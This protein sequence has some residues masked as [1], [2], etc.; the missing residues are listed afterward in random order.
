[1]LVHGKDHPL[2]SS[3]ALAAKIGEQFVAVADSA[4]FSQ[5][6]SFYTNLYTGHQGARLAERTPPA[7]SSAAAAAG[8]PA[9]ASAALRR[10]EGAA[11]SVELELGRLT[12]ENARLAAE[13]KRLAQ[14]NLQFKAP[15][16]AAVWAAAPFAAA[17][18]GVMAPEA[19]APTALENLQSKAPATASVSEATPPALSANVAAAQVRK[20][21][22]QRALA[23]SE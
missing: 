9:S 14:E 20:A 8:V 10:T 11:E 19:A 12:V 2:D 5:K 13:N 4:A 3:T 22:P 7:A 1:M 21:A 16:T 18:H 6:A 23:A 15:A 17:E